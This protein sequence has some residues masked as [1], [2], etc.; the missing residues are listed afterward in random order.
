M[1]GVVRY[2]LCRTRQ[3][4][5]EARNAAGRTDLAAVHRRAV[6]RPSGV[7]S[8]NVK[9]LEIGLSLIQFEWTQ[10]QSASDPRMFI[11]TMDNMFRT[12]R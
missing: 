12:I 11:D 1:K 2:G 9:R 6:I 7:P 5:K 10:C 8:Q 3:L 4:L